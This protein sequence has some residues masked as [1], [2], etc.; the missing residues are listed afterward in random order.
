MYF[1]LMMRVEN[2]AIQGR[3]GGCSAERPPRPRFGWTRPRFQVSGMREIICKD[4]FGHPRSQNLDLAPPPRSPKASDQGHPQ[5]DKRGVRPGPPARSGPKRRLVW[6]RGFPPMRQKRRRMDGAPR[7]LYQVERCSKNL[8]IP[9]FHF[10]NW[11]ID[12]PATYRASPYSPSGG[13]CSR[14]RFQVFWFLRKPFFKS[15]RMRSKSP[16]VR[17]LFQEGFFWNQG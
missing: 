8:S 2:G 11:G 5:L 14:R 7:T 17:R 15:S 10:L 6:V 9:L 1:I 3:G 4:G 12:A 16:L 13:T